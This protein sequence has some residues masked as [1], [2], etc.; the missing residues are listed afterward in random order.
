MSILLL[1]VIDDGI[2]IFTKLQRDFNLANKNH[3]ILELAKGKLTSDPT[4]HSGEGIFF[5][6]RMFDE[7]A[8]LSEDTAFFGHDNDDWLLPDRQM[9]TKGT[10]V[11]MTI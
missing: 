3:A 4:R 1:W 5:T 11:N 2:G 8:I 7:F 10:A 6:S 9:V